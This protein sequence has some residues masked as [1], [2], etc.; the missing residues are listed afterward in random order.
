MC[1][2]FEESLREGKRPR[3]ED[4]LAEG[5]RPERSALLGELLKIELAYRRRDGETPEIAEYTVRFPEDTK[6]LSKVFARPETIN[7]LR[8]RGLNVLAAKKWAGSVEDGIEH[9][10]GYE[11][12]VID[13]QCTGIIQDA[14][15][16]RYTIF[17]VALPFSTRATDPLPAAAAGRP[18][19]ASSAASAST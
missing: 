10:R 16:W 15:L 18:F 4:F 1:D 19:D 7:E 17:A 11:Q 3:I 6:V 14:R 12:I 2:R 5:T 9:L 8:Q 13:P